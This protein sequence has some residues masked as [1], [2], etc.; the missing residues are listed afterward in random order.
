MNRSFDEMLEELEGKRLTVDSDPV[1]ET[2]AVGQFDGSAQID[3]RV[4]GGLCLLVQRV[5]QTALW[6]FLLRTKRLQAFL[7]FNSLREIDRMAASS[8]ALSATNSSSHSDRP[9]CRYFVNGVC[10]MGDRC[11]FSHDR[12][13]RPDMVCRFYL[14]GSCNYGTACR[15]DHIRPRKQHN[16]S[17]PHQQSSSSF[18]SLPR[19]VQLHSAV[20]QVTST[21]NANAPEFVPSWK[22][23]PEQQP[24]SYSNAAG[25]RKAG[26]IKKDL[27]NRPLCPYFETGQCLRGEGCTFVHGLMCDMCQMP[28]LHPYNPELANKHKKECLESHSA[29][30]EEAFA[31]AKSVGKCCGI[32]MENIMEKNLRF[33][34][35]T[36]CK[37]T[38]CLECIRNWRTTHQKSADLQ[39]EVVRSCPQCR[40]HSD[41]VIPSMF[42]VEEEDEKTLLI[43]MYKENTKKKIC[44]YYKTGKMEEACPFG[45]KCFYKHQLPDGSIDPGESPRVRRR[46][47]VLSEFIFDDLD[48]DFPSSDDEDSPMGSVARFIEGR[49][50]AFNF[51]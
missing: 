40:V 34:I 38:F 46:I 45:N 15:Y 7:L 41:Y 11:T 21:L 43:D 8:T 24:E 3:A 29:S 39:P 23:N 42:W 1:I 36:G 12:S 28:R 6:E 48:S 10:R 32:C 50:R 13:Q 33:G 18:A 35:L 27:R 2:L 30:M 26:E 17:Q 44:K 20:P 4:E 51:D 25:G 47:H 19:P 31:L 14:Q 16:Q 5:P 37:H 22:K 49:L 9:L